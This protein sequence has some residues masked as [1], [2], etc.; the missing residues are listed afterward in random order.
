[1]ADLTRDILEEN[2][3]KPCIC[4]AL[5]LQRAAVVVILWTSLRAKGRWGREF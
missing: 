3:E 1:M 2:E 5:V 4:R